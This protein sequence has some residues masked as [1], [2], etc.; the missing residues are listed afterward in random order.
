MN[1]GEIRQAIADK[2][3]D[4]ADVRPLALLPNT[5]QWG[6]QTMIVV[7]PDDPYVT[8]TEGAGRVNQNVVMFRLICLPLPG[9]GAERV[10]AEL[11]ELLSCGSTEPRS[12][13]TV[14]GADVSAG[15]TACALSILSASIRTYRIGESDVTG[16][17][18]QVKVL[19]RC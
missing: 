1:L 16:A 3:A 4:I 8:Y 15:G 12:I 11:D 6:T 5:P 13:R 10:Q 9:K 14:L 17:E 19:A 18:V 2:L 7:Q